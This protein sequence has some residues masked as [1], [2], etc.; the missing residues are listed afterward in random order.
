MTTKRARKP[1]TLHNLIGSR[2]T[3]VIHLRM[4]RCRSLHIGKLGI[5]NFKPESYLYVGSAQGKASTSLGYRLARHESPK[6]HQ[7]WHIDYLL[8]ASEVLAFHF[9]ISSKRMEC[10]IAKRLSIL[11]PCQYKGFGSSDCLQKCG[12]HLFP[13][14]EK[15][16]VSIMSELG[17]AIEMEEKTDKGTKLVKWKETEK[18][19]T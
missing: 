7:R 5:L 3:Y 15:M 9:I 4:A 17:Y 14:S 1:L 19:A 18:K 10:N 2:G 6:K 11:I 16:L 8:G 13:A 12:T